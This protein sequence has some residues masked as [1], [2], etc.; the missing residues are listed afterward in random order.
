MFGVSQHQL[1]INF[2]Y[3]SELHCI[4]V[5]HCADELSHCALPDDRIVEIQGEAPKV[6]KAVEMVVS[7][8]RKFLVDRSIL[9]LFEHI[10]SKIILEVVF[11]FEN[12]YDMAKLHHSST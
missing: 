9:P 10:V 12:I 4:G 11:V 8:L 6:Q 1:Y 2:I 5:S 3:P 7:H